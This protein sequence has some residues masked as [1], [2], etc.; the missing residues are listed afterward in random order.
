MKVLGSTPSSEKSKSN[1]RKNRE[2]RRGKETGKGVGKRKGT[3]EKRENFKKEN[4]LLVCL[5]QREKKKHG[6][7]GLLVPT[8]GCF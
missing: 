3:K 5:T 8:Y 7:P 2:R 6:F 4:K 1:E